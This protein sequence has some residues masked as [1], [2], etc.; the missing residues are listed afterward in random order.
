MDSRM[1]G[2]DGGRS[3]SNFSNDPYAITR[4]AFISQDAYLRHLEGAFLKPPAMP[5]VT[6]FFR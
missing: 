4:R 2:K 5:V 1:R 6:D 3:G